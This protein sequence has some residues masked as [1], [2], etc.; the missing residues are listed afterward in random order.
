MSTNQTLTDTLSSPSGGKSVVQAAPPMQ[1]Q[2]NAFIGGLSRFGSGFADALSTQSNEQF[3][4][5]QESYL[6]GSRAAANA[7]AGGVFAAIE[8]R[9]KTLTT[10][11][12]GEQQGKLPPGTTALH[13]DNVVSDL[14]QQYP[15]YKTEILG[16]LKQ[17]GWDHYLAREVDAETKADDAYQ[18]SQIATA[19]IERD[20]AVHAGVFNPSMSDDENRAAGRKILGA[21][22]QLD[23]LT[24]AADLRVKNLDIDDKTRK[25]QEGQADRDIVRAIG[26]KS[27]VYLAPLVSQMSTFIQAGVSDPS[28]EDKIRQAGPII[29]AAITSHKSE[30]LAEAR[31]AGATK[32]ALDQLGAQYDQAAKDITA[33]YTGDLSI[34]KT[35]E[36][37]RQNLETTFGISA[38]QSFPLI[39]KLTDAFGPQAIAEWS[40]GNPLANMPKE[41]QDGIKD[42]MRGFVT[43]NSQMAN[44]HLMNIRRILAGDTSHFHNLTPQ[45][46]GPTLNGIVMAQTGTTKAIINGDKSTST[47]QT[48]NN[49]YGTVV[50]AAAD[51]TKPTAT[52]ANLQTASKLLN[53]PESRAALK[54]AAT[55]PTT[56][57]AT[58]ETV[59][60]SRSATA[61]LYQVARD[62]LPDT[63]QNNQFQSLKYYPESGKWQI[64]VDK[65][66]YDQWAKEPAD[67]IE[68][69]GTAGMTGT[70]QPFSKAVPPF[71]A[72]Q[73]ADPQLLAKRDI[74]NNALDH[75]SETTEYDKSVPSGLTPLQIRNHYADPG[76]YPFKN[77]TGETPDQAKQ[78]SYDE[79]DKWLTGIQND[80]ISTGLQTG[81]TVAKIIPSK[82]TAF[83]EGQGMSKVATAGI[84]GNLFHES[85]GLNPHAVDGTGSEGIAQWRGDRLKALK[86]FATANKSDYRDGNT[87]LAFAMKELKDNPDLMAKLNAAKTPDEAAEIFMLEFERP[88]GAETGDAKKVLGYNQRIQ[89]S[90]NMYVY[91][92]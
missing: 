33:Y 16:T 41:I 53:S 85:G 44:V 2:P 82:A 79:F 62:T 10:V 80:T 29:Q 34:L 40:A 75:M 64:Y 14:F 43:D 5:Y 83:F 27:S 55:N 84:V 49:S 21:N 66:A 50:N 11:N 12:A 56:A 92:G 23:A 72:F 42:E 1:T 48:F 36:Q 76:K 59:F 63:S 47:L 88:K 17:N 9:Q 68:L 15:E 71:S 89:H 7:T 54:A 19:T 51:I 70:Y 39:R 60:A 31:K 74:L 24:K 61:N 30:A 32:D 52:L 77:A 4:Q 58:R 3:Q 26:D 67:P 35:R 45:E 69:P 20:A 25:L 91:G 22:A 13:I 90:R 38:D 46:I 6:K 8:A 65:K 37:V 87:Q 78:K 73:K 81:D 57:E 18:N 86:D 28:M